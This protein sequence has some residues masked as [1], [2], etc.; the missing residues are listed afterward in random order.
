MWASLV[1]TLWLILYSVWLISHG[2]NLPK[3]GYDTIFHYLLRGG[4]GTQIGKLIG[5]SK[6]EQAQRASNNNFKIIDLL[7]YMLGHAVAVYIGIM[8]SL[9]CFE[10]K[11]FHGSLNAS[12]A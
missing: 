10:T 5:R 3:R 8:V 9:L 6:E 2:M 1:Y 4:L 11:F 7:V 12:M